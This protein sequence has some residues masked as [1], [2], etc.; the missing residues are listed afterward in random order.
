MNRRQLLWL[1]AAMAVAGHLPSCS[2]PD[3][4]GP[5][6]IRMGR[7]QCAECGMI[8]NEDRCSCALLVVRDGAREHLLFDDIGCLLTNRETTDAIVVVEAYVRD[9]A[10]GKWSNFDQASFLMADRERLPT[11]MGSGIVAFAD[12]GGAEGLR[13]SVGGEVLDAGRIQPAHVAWLEAR[14]GKRADR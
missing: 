8:I 5:P 13:A 10:S 3:L 12:V 7:D 11:P 9:H 4:T 6:T 1:T 14:F 2:A